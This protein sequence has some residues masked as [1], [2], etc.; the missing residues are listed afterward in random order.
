MRHARAPEPRQR[1][2]LFSGRPLDLDVNTAVAAAV[3]RRLLLWGHE[4]GGLLLLRKLADESEQ[5]LHCLRGRLDVHDEAGTPKAERLRQL[6]CPLHELGE[7]Y[8]DRRWVEEYLQR[9][10]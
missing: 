10:S 1:S 4:P 5:V 9:A 7:A 2:L 6:A 3:G 8:A